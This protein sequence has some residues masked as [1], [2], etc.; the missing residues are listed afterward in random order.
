MQR[1]HPSLLC[2]LRSDK[3]RWISDLYHCRFNISS[4]FHTDYP[5]MQ[6]I[7]AFTAQQPDELSLEKADI[8]L[9]HKQSNWVEGTRLTDRHRG[10]VPESHLETISSS[11]VKQR[12]WVIYTTHKPEKQNRQDN[13]D[14]A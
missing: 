1:I 9:V 10:W 6:C 14:V 5:Q 2:S 13:I 4:L 11:R 7:R 8:I 12:S 3:L